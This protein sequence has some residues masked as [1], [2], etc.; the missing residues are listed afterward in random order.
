MRRRKDR[1]PAEPGGGIN[2][3]SS[4]TD[5]RP[6]FERRTAFLAAALPR[7]PR[8]RAQRLFVQFD[9]WCDPRLHA[10][11]VDPANQAKLSPEARALFVTPMKK[12]PTLDPGALGRAFALFENAP[13]DRARSLGAGTAYAAGIQAKQDQFKQV[14]AAPDDREAVIRELAAWQ[15]AIYELSY[16]SRRGRPNPELELAILQFATGQLQ[17]EDPGSEWMNSEPDSALFFCFAE[18]CLQAAQRGTTAS[19]SW[20]LRLGVVFAA[21]Q[22]F[23]VIRYHQKGAPRRRENY[24]DDWFDGSREL[25]DD[26]M[27]GRVTAVAKLCPDVGE[28]ARHVSWNAFFAFFDQVTVLAS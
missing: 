12:L 23:Y 18:F 25:P 6:F 26:V 17:I 7:N 9:A 22:D 5:P 19:R 1:R 8:T 13:L 2:S 3:A 11:L 21:A 4:G 16:P 24:G 10:W 27:T 14:G 15:R 20:W 28:L